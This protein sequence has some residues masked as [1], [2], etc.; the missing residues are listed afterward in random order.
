MLFRPMQ[1]VNTSR[2]DLAELFE[3]WLVSKGLKLRR[4]RLW[5]CLM[6][7]IK[8]KIESLLICG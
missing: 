4:V 1:S 8:A 7:I 5:V 6:F 2:S 3:S